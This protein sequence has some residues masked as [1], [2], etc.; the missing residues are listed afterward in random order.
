MKQL[1]KKSLLV[2][3]ND[4]RFFSYLT[5]HPCLKGLLSGYF[6]HLIRPSTPSHVQDPTSAETAVAVLNLTSLDG[7]A[8]EVLESLDDA[9][10]LKRIVLCSDREEGMRQLP[11]GSVVIASGSDKA[12]E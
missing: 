1:E 10:T 3:D 5:G 2:V 7:S 9:Y 8:E 11:P 12:R 6:T 4:S